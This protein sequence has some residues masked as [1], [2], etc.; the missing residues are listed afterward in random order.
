MTGAHHAR[1]SDMMLE[2]ALGLFFNAMSPDT[3]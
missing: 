2:R 1:D 3:A